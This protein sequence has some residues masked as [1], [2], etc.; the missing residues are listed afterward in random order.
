VSD[1]R[2]QLEATLGDSYTIERELGGGGMSRVFLATDRALARRVVIKVLSPELSAEVS[3]KRFARE[4]KLA[5]SLQQANIVPVLS[6]GEIDGT[7]HYVMP[8]VEGL[9]LRDRLERDSRASLGE[10]IGVLRDV[11]RALAYAHGRGIVHRDIKP[12]NILLSG[13]AAVVTDFGV[14]KAIAVAKRSTS[15]AIPH[16]GS[17]VTHVGMAV[18]TPAYMSPEQISAD[19]SVDHRADIYSLGCVAYE[20]LTGSPPFTAESL[21]ALFAA[22]LADPPAPIAARNPDA[23][24]SLTSL[25][26]RCLEKDPALRPQ[27][28]REI[29]EALANVP[30][31]DGSIARIVRRFTPRQQRAAIFAG[32]MAVAGVA[33]AVIVSL[34]IGNAPPIATVAIIPFLNLGGDSTQEYLADGIADELATALGKVRSVRVASRSLGYRYKG[35]RDLDATVVGRA[36]SVNHVVHGSVRRAGNRLIVSAQLTSARDN[37]EVWS[38]R[39]DRSAA[40]AFAVRAEITRG[41]AVAL[42]GEAAAAAAQDEPGTADPR[43]YDLYLRGRFLLQRRG[44]GVR[45]AIENLQQSIAL[46]SGFAQAHGWLALALE[47]Q[48]YFDPVSAREIGPGAIAAASRALELDSTIAEAHTALAMAHQHLYQWPEA[49]RSYRRA[50]D[51]T[52]EDAEA[53][54]QYARFLW[55][56]GRAPEAL[57]IFR[58][59]RELDPYSAQASAWHGHML[60]L[61][62]DRDQGLAEMRRAVE[63]DSTNAPA[64]VFLASSLRTLGQPDE[65]RLLIQRLWRVVPTWRGIAVNLEDPPRVQEI[66]EEFQQRVGHDPHA[67]TRLAMIYAQLDDSTSFFDALERATAAGE[68]WPTYY[69]LSEPFFDFVRGSA[70]FAEI[71]RSVGLDVDIFTSPTGGRVQ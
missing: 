17:T 40:D 48:P 67:N 3:A 13:D 21:P 36:L 34:A 37:R 10:T 43:A 25:V 65:A 41:I 11:A 59:A 22:H 57:P 27:S 7:P 28:A 6:A 32:V 29:L 4:I 31:A 23:P 51:M 45:Q 58:R 26:L 66:L 54:M 55:Y 69:S 24:A 9:S 12:E 39:F 19:P 56:M 52:A 18:G 62:G 50:L 42:G 33:A 1:L 61:R 15:G 38:E 47:L 60:F 16:P 5:A 44:P 63:I 64:I 46:D 8:F 14:A 35:R 53:H 30:T 68:I 20:L 70:R 49:E 71:V 2:T